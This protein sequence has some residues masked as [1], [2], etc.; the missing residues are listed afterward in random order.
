MRAKTLGYVVT[1]QYS[2]PMTLLKDKDTWELFLGGRG[3][4]YTNTLFPS[5][6]AA[7]QA[8]KD[9]RKANTAQWEITRIVSMPE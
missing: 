3:L 1:D 8:I 2:R 6:Q 4:T 5:R 9:K 7:R